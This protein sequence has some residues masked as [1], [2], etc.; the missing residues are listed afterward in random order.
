MT[1]GSDIENGRANSL[2]DMS[3]SSP[4]RARSARRVESE[5]AAKVRSSAGCEYLTIKLSIK[6]PI[7]ACQDVFAK[8]KLLTGRG[9]SWPLVGV[10]V[11]D[12]GAVVSAMVAARVAQMQLAVAAKIAKTEADSGNAVAKLVDAADQ[13]AQQLSAAVEGLGHAIDVSA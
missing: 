11:M 12:I 13:N 7:R 10:C 8:H 9:D 3:S 4:S 5:S 6:P 2:T 1:A